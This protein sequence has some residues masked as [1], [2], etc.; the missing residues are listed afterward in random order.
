MKINIYL[1]YKQKLVAKIFY[2]KK[3][4]ATLIFS[5]KSSKIAQHVALL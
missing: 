1:Y 4:W 3:L 2:K 5:D